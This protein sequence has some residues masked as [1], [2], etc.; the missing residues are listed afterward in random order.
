MNNHASLY[1]LLSFIGVAGLLVLVSV[2]KNKRNK[3][4]GAPAPK[5][6]YVWDIPRYNDVEE[7][8]IKLKNVWFRLLCLVL[9]IASMIE[10]IDIYHRQPLQGLPVTHQERISVYKNQVIKLSL[11]DMDALT[12]KQTILNSMMMEYSICKSVAVDSR[13]Y[14]LDNYKKSGTWVVE[15]KGELVRTSDDTCQYVRSLA[16][17]LLKECSDSAC[18]AKIYNQISK[19]SKT[20]DGADMPQVNFS[21]SSFESHSQEVKDTFSYVGW[22]LNNKGKK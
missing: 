16:N 2:L 17:S 22:Y 18:I 5:I 20:Y 15:H 11:K 10:G 13:K 3:S 9:G 1:I 6:P 4:T 19:Y 14:I 8:F 7:R 21:F 12:K